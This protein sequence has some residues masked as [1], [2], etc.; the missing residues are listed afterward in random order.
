M[1]KRYLGILFILT[2]MNCLSQV[3]DDIYYSSKNSNDSSQHKINKRISL[4]HESRSNTNIGVNT[5][6]L[7]GGG[8]LVGLDFNAML[9]DNVSLQLGFGALSYGAGLNLHLKSD[10]ISPLISCQYW[11]QGVGSTFYASYL[12]PMFIYRIKYFQAGLGIG[13]ILDKGT[14]NTDK[15]YVLLYNIGMFFP[16]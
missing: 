3:K 8:G 4:A 1:K 2:T 14:L 15:K 10:L 16:L 9:A 13:Y 6:V 7:M 5:G 11:H 12:G